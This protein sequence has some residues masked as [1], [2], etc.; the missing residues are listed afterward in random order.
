MKTVDWREGIESL[1]LHDVSTLPLQAA[2][3]LIAFSVCF[4]VLLKRFL[5]VRWDSKRHLI[6]RLSDTTEYKIFT[7][8]D[9]VDNKRITL[10]RD[11]GLRSRS[12]IDLP[13]LHHL[14]SVRQDLSLRS[15][16]YTDILALLSLWYNAHNQFKQRTSTFSHWALNFIVLL[17]LFYVGSSWFVLIQSRGAD[18]YALL[19]VENELLWTAAPR[20]DVSF[21]TL[22]LFFL[23]CCFL[24]NHFQNKAAKTS[25]W[26]L[27][28]STDT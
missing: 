13:Y 10:N 16:I 5:G 1:V 19:H 18:G 12:Q 6:W 25:V 7:R 14:Y 2:A 9:K 28:S 24:S 20:G 17:I 27:V 23:L 11:D 26:G 4:S 8:K 21:K 15:E 3:V 22:I